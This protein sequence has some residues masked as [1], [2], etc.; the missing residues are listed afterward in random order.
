MCETE[1]DGERDIHGG[2]RAQRDI[3][4]CNAVV[5]AYARPTALLAGV[6]NAVVLAYAHPAAVLALASNAVVL[7]YATRLVAHIW[8]HTSPFA[9]AYRESA[10]V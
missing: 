7:A 1:R 6:S 8:L 9:Y 4:A 5:L 2:E 10:Y 3:L